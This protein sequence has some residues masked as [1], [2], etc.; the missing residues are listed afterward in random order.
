MKRFIGE[1]VVHLGQTGGGTIM[2]TDLHWRG[3]MG[4]NGR[5]IKIKPSG[6][7]DENIDLVG[8]YFLSYLGVALSGG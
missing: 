2:K 8:G 4:R 5:P 7:T 3:A 1:P 6:Q